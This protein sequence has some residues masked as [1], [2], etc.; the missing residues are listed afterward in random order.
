MTARSYQI[1]ADLQVDPKLV[2]DQMLMFSH[3]TSLA[4]IVAHK[5]RDAAHRQLLEPRSFCPSLMASHNV[6]DIVAAVVCLYH[7]YHCCYCYY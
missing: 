2:F 5:Q 6:I 1:S 4:K 7:D 3:N